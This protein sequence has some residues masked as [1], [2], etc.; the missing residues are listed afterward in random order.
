[1]KHCETVSGVSGVIDEHGVVF[2]WKF[3]K[4]FSAEV[5]ALLEG[6]RSGSSPVCNF[7]EVGVKLERLDLFEVEFQ[8]F[9]RAIP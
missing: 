3:V 2:G 4:Q 7:V 1:M 6:G 5:K 9:V 8:R